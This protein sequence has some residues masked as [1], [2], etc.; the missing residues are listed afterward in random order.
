MKFIIFGKFSWNHIYFLFYPIC[1]LI[2]NRLTNNLDKNSVSRSFYFFYIQLLSRFIA[3]IPYIINRQLSKRKNAEKKDKNRENEFKYIYNETKK[4]LSKSLIK[5]TLRVAIFDFLAEAVIRIFNFINNKPQALRYSMQTTFVINAMTQYIVSYFVLNYHF[6][7]HHILSFVIN[8]FVIVIFLIIDIAEIVDKKITDYQFYI[9]VLVRI[10]QLILSSIYDNYSKQTLL[11]QFLTPFSLMLFNAFYEFIFLI[12]FS[13]PFIFLKT[14]DTGELIF[15]DFLKYLKGIKLLIS[16]GIL[17]CD[18]FFQIFILI[19][20]DRFSPSHLPFG[21]IISSF[22]YNLY[23]IIKNSINNNKTKWY[24][25][26]YLPLYI[27]L[28]ISVMIHNE[29][30]IIN[31]WGFNENTKLFLNY[32]LDEEKSISI[33]KENGDDEDE[34]SDKNEEQYEN[35]LPIEDLSENN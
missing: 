16:F 1:G 31:K 13:I 20:I 8:I 3:F 7:K 28:F 17:F 29:I 18:F 12:V 11:T 22:G 6:Y 19:V 5:S 15:V 32:K 10:I 4:V 2:N 26:S 14:N 30:F 27:I 34:N 25:Y 35:I 9:F 23:T 24:N 33:I 21:F